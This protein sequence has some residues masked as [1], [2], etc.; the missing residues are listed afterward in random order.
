MLI[1]GV[2]DS[3]CEQCCQSEG[4]LSDFLALGLKSKG[5]TIPV[6]RVDTSVKSSTALFLKY[7]IIF[8]KVPMILLYRDDRFYSFNAAFN[9]L[10]LLIHQINRLLNPMVTLSTEEEV[11]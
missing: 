3:Q 11:E 8:E 4:I 6:V 1:I 5:K 2:G 9:R 10:D 7:D